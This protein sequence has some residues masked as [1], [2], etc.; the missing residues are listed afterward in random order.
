MAEDIFVSY[1]HCSFMLSIIVLT[2]LQLFCFGVYLEESKL[3]CLFQSVQCLVCFSFDLLQQAMILDP[4]D[5]SILSAI[6]R[7]SKEMTKERKGQRSLQYY[8]FRI[9]HIVRN[10]LLY[11]Y[12]YI[13][14]HHLMWRSGYYILLTMFLGARGVHA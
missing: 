11:A 2:N 3:H 4:T 5:E 14:M 10:T 7:T 1:S 12:I 13:Y 8:I 6:S 9:V